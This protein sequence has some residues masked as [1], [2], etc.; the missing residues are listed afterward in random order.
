[1]RAKLFVG[2]LNYETSIENL[3]AVFRP[4]QGYLHTKV[5]TV[6]ASVLFSLRKS[7][8]DCRPVLDSCAL[9]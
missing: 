3:E 4:F 2:N 6:L 1:M 9:T 8:I 5:R 7:C